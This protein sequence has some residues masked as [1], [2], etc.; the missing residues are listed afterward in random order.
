MIFHDTELNDARLIELQPF[1]DD[2]GVFARTFCQR[3]FAN[4]GLPTDFVQQNMSSSTTKGTIRGLHFQRPPHGEAKLIRC[5]NGVILD[6]IVD[7]RAGSSTYLRHASFELSSENRRQLFIPAGFA[8]GFQ[9]L[10][11]NVEVSYLVSAFYTP[12]A[13]GGLRWNDPMLAIEW[14][15]E[16]TVMS[17]KDANWPLLDRDNPLRL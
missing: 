6:V 11:D 14:P 7:L 2:R 3:E 5:V 4:A 10:T 13:E 8:H 9:T 16:A 17:A 1:G 15:L 12:S